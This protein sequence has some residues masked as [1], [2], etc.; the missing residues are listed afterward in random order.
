MGGGQG[1]QKRVGLTPDPL[2][3][4]AHRG[5]EV[6]PVLVVKHE[7]KGVVFLN[8]TPLHFVANYYFAT[9]I[10]EGNPTPH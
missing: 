4:F 1:G 3:R 10:L 2:G 8:A 9:E 5:L 7:A 6:K